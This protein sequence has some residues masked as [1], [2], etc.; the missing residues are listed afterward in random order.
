MGLVTVLFL[1][2]ASAF[3]CNGMDSTIY[4]S[5]GAANGVFKKARNGVTFSAFYGI[6]YAKPPVGELRFRR[7]ELADIWEGVRP[8]REPAAECLQNPPG[9]ASQIEGDED[10]LFVNVFTRHPKDPNARRPVIVWIHGGAFIFGGAKIYGP[11][12]MMEE[13][14]VLVVVQYRLN[15]FGF[16]STEDEH[17]PG[18]YGMWDQTMALTWIQHYIR[19][20]GGDPAKVTLTG[21]SA[22]GA[23][24]HYHVLCPH[25]IGLFHNAISFSGSSLNW[26]AHIRNPR[27]QALTVAERAG[28]HQ[29]KHDMSLLVDCLRNVEA[30][31]L[32][33]AQDATFVWHPDKNEREPMNSFSPRHDDNSMYRYSFAPEH[34][35]TAMQK[36][37][38][39]QVP[40]MIGLAEKEGGWRANY[41]LPDDDKGALWKEFAEKFDQLAPYAFG[42]HG[43]QSEEP[44]KIVQKMKDFYGLS[45]LNPITEEKVHAYIDAQSDTMFNLGIQQTVELHAHHAKRQ[46]TYLLYVKYPGRLSLTQMRLNG[47][48]GRHPLEALH[49]A[50]HGTEMLLMF[51]MFAGMGEMP[52]EDVAVSRKFIKT[53]VDFAQF[54]KPSKAYGWEPLDSKK[55]VYYEIDKEF[56]VRKGFP[57]IFDRLKFW[58]E[59]D[60][61]AYWKFTLAN[62][63]KVGEREEL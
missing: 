13:D 14:I 27:E 18:N 4:T 21:M 7:P 15:I 44:D 17:L 9:D 63:A 48:F 50:T 26:W 29:W 38:I 36:G 1:S 34:P 16:L 60:E 58:H 62:Q 46:P 56:K 6:P 19:D 2:L 20:Y 22:G 45:D 49:M 24:V 39:A 8:A 43:K 11:E 54:G 32:M 59:L 55:P 40:Y 3:L 25:N 28:C 37:E 51:P 57:P 12:Y 42:L 41:V 30:G 47:T 33:R 31:D 35:F 53:L 5:Q 52:D 23:S 61:D 10:C